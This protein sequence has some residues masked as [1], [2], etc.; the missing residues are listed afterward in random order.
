VLYQKLGDNWYAFTELDGDC[1]MSRVD[2]A[3]MEA[4]MAQRQEERNSSATRRKML[5]AA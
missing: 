1:Y 4:H 3:A 5:R 2:D